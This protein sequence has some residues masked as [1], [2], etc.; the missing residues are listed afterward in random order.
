MQGRLIGYRDKVYGNYEPKLDSDEWKFAKEAMDILENGG[1]PYGIAPGNHD[2]PREYVNYNKIFPI[3][4]WE[5]KKWFGGNFPEGKSQ[6]TY[7]LL[8]HL[9][10]VFLFLQIELEPLAPEI[11][12]ANDILK[13]YPNHKV[14]MTSHNYMI[15][16]GDRMNRDRI[17]NEVLKNYTNVF[18][19]FCGH[20]T[21]ESWRIDNNSNGDPI[22]QILTDFQS[23][24][25]NEWEGTLRSLEFDLTSNKLQTSIYNAHEDIYPKCADPGDCKFG[26]ENAL[27]EY[28]VNNDTVVTKDSVVSLQKRKRRSNAFRVTRHYDLKGR[29][30]PSLKW[31]EEWEYEDK[32]LSI[33]LIQIYDGGGRVVVN[34]KTFGT[35]SD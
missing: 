2:G 7:F 1:I 10:I 15:P 24:R 18:L 8:S 12:W 20:H 30:I 5:N 34:Q 4:L 26:T 29:T 27:G 25:N 14:I 11:Q 3:S 19:M 9:G 6:N 17:W 16:N 31:K 28:T 35:G 32:P 13:K 21:G 33:Y 23:R 22:L